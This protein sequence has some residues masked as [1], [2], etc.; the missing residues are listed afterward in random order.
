MRAYF[1]IGY[2]EEDNLARAEGVQ[3]A[4]GA[5]CDHG[6]EETMKRFSS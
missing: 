5:C 4:K 1:V 2:L 3:E 6:A